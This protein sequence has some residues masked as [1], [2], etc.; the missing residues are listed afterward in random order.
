MIY[1][2]NS[3]YHVLLTYAITYEIMVMHN[4]MPVLHPYLINQINLHQYVLILSLEH[5]LH[6]HLLI[7]LF[8][9][10]VYELGGL[11]E[12]FGLVKDDNIQLLNNF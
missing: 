5:H 6:H 2:Y 8:Y 9:L 1:V 10:D 3:I 4:L 7:M 11:L 12:L